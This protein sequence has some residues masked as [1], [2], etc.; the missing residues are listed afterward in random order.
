MKKIH[1]VG[2][3]HGCYFTLLDLLK[4]LEDNI[5]II[6]FGDLYSKEVINLV[7]KINMK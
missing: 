6:F 5:R 2:N 7:I 4:R 3:V 1:I